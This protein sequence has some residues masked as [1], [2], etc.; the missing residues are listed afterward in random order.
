MNNVQIAIMSIAYLLKKKRTTISPKNI[1]RDPKHINTTIALK[2]LDN[3]TPNGIK[4][5]IVK[6][7]HPNLPKNCFI[8]YPP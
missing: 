4:S 7:N 6:I 8:I 2:K 1:A 5:K 3:I